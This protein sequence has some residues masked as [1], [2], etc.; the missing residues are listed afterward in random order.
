MTIHQIPNCF[1]LVTDREPRYSLGFSVIVVVGL[2]LAG[3]GLIGLAVYS[4]L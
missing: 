1:E 4:F 3:W 2:A